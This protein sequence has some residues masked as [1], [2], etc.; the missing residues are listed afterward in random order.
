MAK[1]RVALKNHRV[2]RTDGPNQRV[3]DPHEFRR[4]FLVRIGDIDTPIV[5]AAAELENLFEVQAK[6]VRHEPVITNFNLILSSGQ[7]VQ[8]RR[9]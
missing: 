7:P 9:P 6:L 4:T 3:I 8:Q 5:L 1:R 2:D